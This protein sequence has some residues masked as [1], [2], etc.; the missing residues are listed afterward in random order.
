MYTNEV[1]LKLNWSKV[2]FPGTAY[3]LL[4][5]FLSHAY[6]DYSVFTCAFDF[7][8]Q[9]YASAVYDV[10]VCPSVCPSQADTVSKNG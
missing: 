10:V 8:A 2:I 6:C 9:R 5:L 3:L 1:C 4:Q 7:T